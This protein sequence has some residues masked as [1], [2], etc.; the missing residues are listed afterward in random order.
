MAKSVQIYWVTPIAMLLALLVG[1]LVALGHHLFYSSLAGKPAPTG[2]YSIAGT[3][4][5]KQQFNT[6]VGTAFAFLVKAALAIAVGI[7]YIQA[8]WH[9]ARV[10]KKGATLASLDT[11]YS[12]LSNPLHLLRL[13]VWWRH[14]ILLLLAV[15]AWYARQSPRHA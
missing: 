15:I 5:S 8:F 2:A 3:N 7:S 10:S 4:I 12:V 6:A 14:P 11:S 13:N 1:F 9:S